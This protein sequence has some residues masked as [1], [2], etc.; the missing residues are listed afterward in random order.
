[1]AIAVG[2]GLPTLTADRPWVEVEWKG[3]SVELIR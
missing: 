3:L 1:M 2:F